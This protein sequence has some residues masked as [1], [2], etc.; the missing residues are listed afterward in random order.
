MKTAFLFAGQGAQKPGMGKDFY[1]HS[2]AARELMDSLKCGFDLKKVCFEGPAEVLNN[3]AYCQASVVAVSTSI[4]K[5]VEEAGFH[6]DV[7]AGLSLG[8][9][10]ALVCAGAMTPQTAVSIVEQRGKIMAEALPEGTTGMSAVLGLDA[11]SISEV[12]RQVSREGNILEVAN[13]NCPGQIVV[14]GHMPALAEAQPLLTAKGARRVIPL[15]VSGA[16]HSSL[17]NEASGKLHTVLE[18]ADLSAPVLP[19]YHNLTGKDEHAAGKEDLVRIL[20][21]QICHSVLFEQTIR[22]MISDGVDTFVEIGPGRT[23]TGFVRKVS[24]DVRTFT[25]NTCEDLERM[26]EEWKKA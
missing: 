11:E 21:Q 9:Y 22:N 16:F 5:A 7:T 8:E 2:T 18:G 13:Y 4:L 1:D 19:V 6:A 15:T 26:K 14:T 25:I 17:L 12:C 3:T 10:S 24:R 23:L 20:T